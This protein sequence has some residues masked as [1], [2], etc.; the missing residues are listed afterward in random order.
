VTNQSDPLT[1]RP[2]KNNSNSLISSV[3]STSAPA[4]DA[5]STQNT[6]T[7]NNAGTDALNFVAY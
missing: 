4:T 3:P 7:V 1:T 6:L 5:L 2:S